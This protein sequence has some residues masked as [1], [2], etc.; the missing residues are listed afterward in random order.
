M[1]NT[2]VISF[3][4]V[5]ISVFIFRSFVLKRFN[6]SILRR[7][8]CFETLDSRNERTGSNN[9]SKRDNTQELMKRMSQ[10]NINLLFMFTRY[11]NR[12]N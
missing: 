3:R 11:E 12:R 10:R 6:C 7:D 4:N 5:T 2:S 1:I 8:S 9:M